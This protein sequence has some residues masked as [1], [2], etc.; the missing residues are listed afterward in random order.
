MDEIFAK[1]YKLINKYCRLIKKMSSAE[2][3]MV[4]GKNPQAEL[5]KNGSL[6]S[7]S[8]SETDE[9]PIKKRESNHKQVNHLIK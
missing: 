8:E 1:F 5:I 6:K 7:S 2:Y 3:D 4:S 9:P